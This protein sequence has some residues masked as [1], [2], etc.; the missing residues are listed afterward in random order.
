MYNVLIVTWS[1]MQRS[2]NDILQSLEPESRKELRDS[3]ITMVLATDMQVTQISSI[4]Q[5]L[6][7]HLAI[8]AELQTA[9]TTKRGKGEWFDRQVCRACVSQSVSGGTPASHWVIL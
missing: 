5:Y 4:I 9:I 3:M 6:Q 7:S 8:V 2:E 1:P